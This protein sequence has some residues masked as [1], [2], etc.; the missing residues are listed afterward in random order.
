MQ[1]CLLHDKKLK[2]KKRDGKIN[3]IVKVIAVTAIKKKLYVK[4]YFSIH[5]NYNYYSLSSV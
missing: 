1:F 2:L 5:V 3:K 4:I